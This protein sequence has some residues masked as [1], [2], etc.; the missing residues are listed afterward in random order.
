MR[1]KNNRDLTAV[2]GPEN[3]SNYSAGS[4]EY[5]KLDLWRYL[6]YDDR[7]K[8]INIMNRDSFVNNWLLLPGGPDAIAA[9]LMF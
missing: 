4:R 5:Y 6:Q 7:D 3:D 8:K 2:Y 1:A 9:A